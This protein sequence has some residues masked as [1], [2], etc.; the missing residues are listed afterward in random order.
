MKLNMFV[1]SLH[2]AQLLEISIYITFVMKQNSISLQSTY[3][4]RRDENEKW[5]FKFNQLTGS[6]NEPSLITGYVKSVSWPTK[7][8]FSIYVACYIIYPV[9]FVVG[10][11][12]LFYLCILLL[13]IEFF[14]IR[15]ELATTFR[16][17]L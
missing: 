6:I 15:T 13:L 5:R 7:A 9:N 8:R 2:L 16:F 14:L 3:Q 10:L 11:E 1:H 17:Q 12:S 4:W